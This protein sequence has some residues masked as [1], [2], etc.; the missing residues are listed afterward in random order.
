MVPPLV[1]MVRVAHLA[2]STNAALRAARSEW[3]LARALIS[4]D[5]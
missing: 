1:V 3:C 4:M 5:Q 2:H